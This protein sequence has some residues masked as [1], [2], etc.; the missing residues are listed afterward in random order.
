MLDMLYELKGANA[1]AVRVYRKES[2]NGHR[3]DLMYPANGKAGAPPGLGQTKQNRPKP[4]SGG[5]QK[6]NGVNKNK[7]GHAKPSGSANYYN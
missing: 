5:Q 6:Q 3:P 2:L 4:T 7:R 1:S